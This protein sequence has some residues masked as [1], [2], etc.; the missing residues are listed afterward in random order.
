MEKYRKIGDRLGLVVD[1]SV[2]IIA[3]NEA[4]NIAAALESVRWVDDVVVVD[5]GSS[6][7]TIEIAKR[8]TER[9]TT[10]Q[11]EGY[12]SQK[13]YAT[14]LAS[15]DWV[16]SI[17]ADERVSKELAEEI[18][19]LMESVPVM[20]GYRIPRTTR[21]LG[22]WIRSTDWYPDR[23]LRLYDRR[24]AQWNDRYIH[25]S[26]RVQGRVGSLRAELYHHS[27][28]GIGEHLS[29]MNHYTTLAAA[30]MMADGRRTNWLDLIAYP[31][32]VFFRN[33]I[34]RRGFSDYLPGL[35]VSLMNT[36]YVLCKYAKLW[37]Q[38]TKS[39]RTSG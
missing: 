18:Q 30:Q 5:S 32:L 12:G 33:Y 21:Y 28:R 37:E 23:Q 25:E 26:V 13:N 4:E 20:Q 17:D 34:W 7:R 29:R 19:A 1:L 14:G 22:R 3:E 31:P 38:Q 39:K 35:I 6:D 8:Y 2:V 11:W 15:H 16:L 9:V 10:R 36:Y 27:Y 24:V